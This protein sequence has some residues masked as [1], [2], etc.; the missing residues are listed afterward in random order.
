MKKLSPLSLVI[1]LFASQLIVFLIVTIR[2][3][4]LAPPKHIYTVLSKNYL[5][6]IFF[7]PSMILQAKDGAWSI[8]DTHTTAFQKR[9]AAQWFFILAGKIAQLGNIEPAY[10]FLLLQGLGGVALF[11]A[12]YICITRLLPASFHLAALLFALSIEVGPLTAMSAR[13]PAFDAQILVFRNFGLAHHAWGLAMGLFALYLLFQAWYEPTKTRFVGVFLVSFA[14]TIILPPLMLTIGLTV[15]PMLMLRAMM[16]GRIK[17]LA[18]PLLLA[19]IAIGIVGVQT[20]IAF[21]LAGP[22]WDSW[23]PSEKSWWDSRQILYQ[24]GRSLLLYIPFFILLSISLP[25]RWKVWSQE[26]RDLVVAFISWILLPI[27]LIPL[28]EFDFFP[29]ANMRIVD[30]YHFIPAGILAAIGLL[31]SITLLPIRA[32]KTVCTVLISGV[33]GVSLFLSIG[34]HANVLSTQQNIQDTHAYPAKTTWEA[35][36]FLR[37]VPRESGVLAREWFGEIIPGFANVRV[38]IGGT[39]GFPDWLDRKRHVEEFFTG[40][41]SD[42]KAAD[43]LRSNDI[44]YVFYGP[45]EQALT[46]TSS[47]YPKILTSVFDSQTAMI[48][49]VK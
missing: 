44:D 11:A 26:L 34:Y 21:T 33:V 37:T 19:L 36:Q 10:L 35:V 17:K 47:L 30:G 13:I 8:L 5:Y 7:Y 32:Q 4:H 41:V 6:P 27:L 3:F 46:T 20:N 43:F 18:L 25:F 22:P 31:Q 2:P 28:S 9:V 12:T 1:V 15:C 45:D 48:L 39:H 40:T 23:T 29:I 14:A 24:Y 49:A 42:T 16:T 38:Y